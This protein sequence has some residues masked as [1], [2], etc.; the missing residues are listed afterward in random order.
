MTWLYRCLVA[1]IVAVAFSP[2]ASASARTTEWYVGGVS[3]KEA[4]AVTFSGKITLQSEGAY[5]GEI[6]CE[7][8]GTGTVGEK[9][10]G[11][12]SGAKFSGCTLKPFGKS[13]ACE[14]RFPVKIYPLNLPWKT[15]VVLKQFQGLGEADYND[16]TATSG[17]LGVEIECKIIG[18]ESHTKCTTGEERAQLRN[19]SNVGVFERWEAIEFGESRWSCNNGEGSNPQL[20]V[21]ESGTMKATAGVLTVGE[22]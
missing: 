9:G 15:Q 7:V 21:F 3:V 4:K 13:T 18:L 5:V 14:E 12:I 22:P 6:H 2:V 19:E 16:I 8:S 1:V 20:Q 11:A 10:T 17:S